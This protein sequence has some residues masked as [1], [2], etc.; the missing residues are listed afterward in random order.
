MR[1]IC[2]DNLHTFSVWHS[3]ALIQDRPLLEQVYFHTLVNF[4][5]E[6]FLQTV[7]KL[8]LG[9]LDLSSLMRVLF[10]T[11]YRRTT[12]VEL[13]RN[14][15]TLSQ[16]SRTLSRQGPCISQL[17]LWYCHVTSQSY[18]MAYEYSFEYSFVLLF[19]GLWVIWHGS[20]PCHATGPRLAGQRTEEPRRTRGNTC[21]SSHLCL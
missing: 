20:A 18:A 4:S 3:V 15:S 19:I 16:F 11:I 21:Y 7:L 12:G 5:F 2:I 9:V 10:N 17:C 1:F 6:P 8:W 13:Q 14:R